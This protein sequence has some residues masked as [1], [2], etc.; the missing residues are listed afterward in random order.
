MRRDAPDP[1]RPFLRRVWQQDIAPLLRGK[2]ASQRRKAARTAGTVAAATGLLVDSLFHLRGR[3]FTRF[4]TVLGAS[5][6]A[7]LPD[8]WSWEWFR[9]GADEDDRELIAER[10]KSRASEL[11]EADALA[12]FELSPQATREE[13]Q[14]AWR[15]VIQRWHPDKARDDSQRAEFH[16]RFV[17]FQ[18]AYERL[19][20]A[21]DGGALPAPAKARQPQR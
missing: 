2:H 14:E 17:A 21:Y 7:M 8:V 19:C 3:P 12:L 15:G 6:G 18:S 10:I 20:R 11:P 16:V 9:R 5:M 1:L 4:M 13:L